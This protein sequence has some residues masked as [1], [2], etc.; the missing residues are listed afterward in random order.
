MKKTISAVP[1]YALAVGRPLRWLLAF[2]LFLVA[3]GCS[4]NVERIDK[5]Q[6]PPPPPRPLPGQTGAAAPPGGAGGEEAPVAGA[7]IHGEVKI[8]P[9]LASKIGPNAALFVFARRPG[10]GP[11]AATRI[12]SPEF[13]V[14]YTLTGQNVMFSDEG[15]SGE[16]DI[17]ARI[18]QSGTAGPANPGDLSGAA[19]GNPVTVGDGQ[20]HD[21]L[22][23]TEH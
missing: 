22:I 11:V 5:N 20:P 8:A 19:P 9:E 6:P 10:G 18:S 23:D 21:I 17:V 1:T 13:P 15:L 7:S 16:L 2:A 14:H 4:Q 12:G 3:V